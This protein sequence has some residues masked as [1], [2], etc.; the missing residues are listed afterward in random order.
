[1]NSCWR[2]DKGDIMGKKMANVTGILGILFLV[3]LT[4]FLN[5]K[6]GDL[7]LES[8]GIFFMY[9]I[10]FMLVYSFQVIFGGKDWGLFV[11]LGLLFT[12]SFQRHPYVF[13]EFLKINHRIRNINYIFILFFGVCFFCFWM[14]QKKKVEWRTLF[15]LE[16]IRNY[17]LYLSPFFVLKERPERALLYFIIVASVCFFRN[18]DWLK[19][20]RVREKIIMAILV[21]AYL[22]CSYISRIRGFHSDFGDR[23]FYRELLYYLFFGVLLIIPISKEMF[24]KI[25]FTLIFS[26]IYPICLALLEWT[27]NGYSLYE[28]IGTEEWTSMWAVRA[29]MISLM[30]FFFYFY[31]RNMILLFMALVST[32]TMFLSQGRGP[33]LSFLLSFLGMIFFWCYHSKKIK[34][35]YVSVFVLGAII[36]ALLYTDNFIVYKIKLALSNQDNS[37]NT[38]IILYKGAI[39]QWKT[40]PYFGHGLGTLKQTA[41]NMKQNLLLRYDLTRIPH[42]H[43]NALELLRS[44]GLVG[45]SSYIMMRLYMLSKFLKGGIISIL[46]LVLIVSFE[47]SGVTDYTLMM[48]RAHILLLFIMGV[49]FSAYKEI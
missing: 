25:K 7:Y 13:R 42:A 9:A 31:E 16:N 22:F 29:G 20:D 49:W 8:V 11:F 21:A 17:F 10:I 14:F 30:Y 43:D 4:N 1:M 2:K 5:G 24:Q 38:R 6:R 12:Y 23:I 33:L 40:S 35:F 36:L 19:V 26:G 41:E 47:L 34:Y 44:L 15:S 27:Y 46:P 18:K 37:T 48:F 32:L 28:A 45:I 3:Q 39:E